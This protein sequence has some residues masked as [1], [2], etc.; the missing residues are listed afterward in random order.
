VEHAAQQYAVVVGV[1]DRHGA[2][3]GGR[4]ASVDWPSGGVRGS[5]E[6][7]EQSQ[8]DQVTGVEADASTASTPTSAA[9][10]STPPISAGQSR[11]KP[12]A[13]RAAFHAV[14]RDFVLRA[15]TCRP[16][17]P[18]RWARSP[19]GRYRGRSR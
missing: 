15:T 10:S 19:R 5:L 17:F 7:G 4:S 14:F 1:G 18:V 8:P 12:R 9:G 11:R 6:C 2:G 16:G 13:A 3:V